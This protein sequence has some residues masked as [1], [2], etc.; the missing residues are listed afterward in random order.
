MTV[1]NITLLGHKDHGKSTLIGNL[2]ILTNSVTKTRIKEAETYSKR[3]HRD[4][5]PAFIL[6]SFHEEREGGLTIDVTRAEMQYR[7][8][9]FSFIDVPGH[10]ELIKN[11]ISG[12]SYASTALL[13]VSAKSGEGI[14]DQT[15]RHLFIARML[16]IDGLVV[17]V[18]KMDLVGYSEA[19]F[20]AIKE[21]LSGFITAIGFETRNVK[22]IPIS[23]YTGENLVNCSK[24]MGWYGGM[25]LLDALYSASKASSA[26][27]SGPLRLLVQ[28]V[29][30]GKER[31]IA[32]RIIKGK[33]RTGEEACLATD[34][35]TIRIKS[36]VVKGKRVSSAKAGENVAIGVDKPVNG[37]LRGSLICGAEYCPMPRNTITAKIFLTKKLGEKLSIRFNGID[38]PCKGLRVLKYVDAVTGMESPHGTAKPLNALVAELSLAKKIAVE[39]FNDTRELGRFVF[40]SDGEFAGIGTVQ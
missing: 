32:G 29:L 13:L 33:L 28:G 6:D 23:A 20:E 9:T 3:L 18:N 1:R 22:F 36:I 26:D 12:A 25:S 24:R 37:G 10:E 31:L 19:S 11:M 21:S 30:D 38:I 7:R 40:Y 39:S 27:A 2:L 14:R 8:T 34:R 17:A 16:G 5:E 4:F 15:K 35:V